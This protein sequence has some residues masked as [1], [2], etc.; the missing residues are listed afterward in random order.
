MAELVYHVAPSHARESILEH[1]LQGGRPL[2]WGSRLAAQ[3]FGVYVWAGEEFARRWR[4]RSDLQHPCPG[5]DIWAADP[6]EEPVGV[7]EHQGWPSLIVTCEEIPA[8]RLTL[9]SAGA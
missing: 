1:G 8:S 3:P 6:G 7:D 4:D 2:R 5:G 9:V